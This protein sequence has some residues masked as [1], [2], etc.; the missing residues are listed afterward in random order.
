MYNLGSPG[1]ITVIAISTV[2]CSFT[3]AQSQSSETHIQTVRNTDFQFQW[4]RLRE[5]LGNLHKHWISKG[6]WR[7]G[8]LGHFRTVSAW[9]SS[10]GEGAHWCSNS[11][12]NLLCVL[13]IHP[14]PVHHDM[15]GVMAQRPCRRRDLC[16]SLE[17]R[18]ILRVFLDTAFTSHTVHKGLNVRICRSRSTR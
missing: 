12:T 4:S 5:E 15:S 8:T 13:N 3:F 7:S 9:W 16:R 6:T 2:C 10:F 14:P 18:D 17:Q 1:F 11:S